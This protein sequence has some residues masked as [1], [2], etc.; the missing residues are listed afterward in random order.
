M[1]RISVF[2]LAV[3]TLAVATIGCNSAGSGG[4]DPKAV[5]LAF[6]EK[7]SKKDFEGAAQ[8][9]TKESKSFIDMMKMGMEMAEKF[10]KMGG[11]KPEENGFSDVKIGDAKINGDVAVVPFT[12]KGQSTFDF[13]LKKE[14]GAWKV[15][16]T[17][18]TMAKMGMDAKGEDGNSAMD[19][20]K[21]MN[22]D[23][24]K[25]GMQMLDTMMKSLTPE[26][27]E[28]LKKMGEEMEKAMK[29]MKQ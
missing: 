20:M 17:M 24:M 6:S 1:K 8:L 16:L 19:E 14:N 15:D 27:M 2:L 28:E 4:G 12:A 25:K 21:N 5:V 11:Q 29:D 26:K 7:L 18:E 13:P 23:S 22:L 10:G 9:A 3:C